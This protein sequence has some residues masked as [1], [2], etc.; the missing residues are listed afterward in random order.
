M[1]QTRMTM[2]R[3]M[4][5]SVTVRTNGRK[6]LRKSASLWHSRALMKM[7]MQAMTAKSLI[8]PRSR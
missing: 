7:M 4:K 5:S 1:T 2:M 3:K 8:V 6:E